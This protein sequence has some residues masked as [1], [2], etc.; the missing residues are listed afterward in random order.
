MPRVLM[1]GNSDM[2]AGKY[3]AAT[4]NERKRQQQEYRLI[5]LVSS[6]QNAFI[7]VCIANDVLNPEKASWSRLLIINAEKRL[8]KID[9]DRCDQQQPERRLH[10][11]LLIAAFTF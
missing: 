1:H 11:E 2:H 4:E 5:A 9:I 8:K 10:S 3:D 6:C 7:S